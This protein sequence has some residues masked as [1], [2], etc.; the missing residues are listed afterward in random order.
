LRTWSD[1]K[2]ASEVRG[3]GGAGDAVGGRF[4]RGGGGGP[5]GKGSCHV[6]SVHV[7]T[8]ERLRGFLRERIASRPISLGIS[9]CMFAVAIPRAEFD[10]FV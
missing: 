6:D 3:D 8:D 5:I 7:E 10:V 9:A 1:A 2:F 4:E